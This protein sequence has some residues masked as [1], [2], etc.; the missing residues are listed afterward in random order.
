MKKKINLQFMFISAVGIL[1]TFC[2]STVIFYELF[3][4][5]VVDE[6]KTYADV[7][8]ETQS[9][10]QILQGEYDP[11]VDDLRITMIKKTEKSFTTVL[12]MQKK[13]RTMQIGRRSARH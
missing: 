10:D 7:I 6:L 1:L 12:R 13:W 9:Y 2:L 3:K 11:D 5:E 4:S 8:K